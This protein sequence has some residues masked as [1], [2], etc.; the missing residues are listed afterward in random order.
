V[1]QHKRSLFIY[2][3]RGSRLLESATVWPLTG[4]R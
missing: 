3:N 1:D 4:N 2:H